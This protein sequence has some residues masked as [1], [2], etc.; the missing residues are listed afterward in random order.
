MQGY[1][2]A[3]YGILNR[4]IVDERNAEPVVIALLERIGHGGHS[5]LF[6]YRLDVHGDVSVFLRP[7]KTLALEVSDGLC[8]MANQV[9]VSIVDNGLRIVEKLHLL[10]TFLLKRREVLLM[11]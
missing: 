9:V 10:C 4:S 11:G 7:D 1:K 6:L 8:L 5:R 3:D 2:G